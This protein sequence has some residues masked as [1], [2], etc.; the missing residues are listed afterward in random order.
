MRRRSASWWTEPCLDVP[1][2]ARVHEGEVQSTFATRLVHLAHEALHV[3][4]R[5]NFL[6]DL[7]P[8]PWPALVF[9]LHI[10]R[11]RC[12]G[13]LRV[14]E[15]NGVRTVRQVH[16]GSRESLSHLPIFALAFDE[17]R[18]LKVDLRGAD[19]PEG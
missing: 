13:I 5:D 16:D 4:G 7:G 15:N 6:L 19:E 10:T 12:V 2:V 17:V 14:A 18:E 8:E 9:D 1:R 3:S 11:C